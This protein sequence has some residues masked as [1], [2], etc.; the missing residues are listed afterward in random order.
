M[1]IL[2][3]ALQHDYLQHWRRVLECKWCGSQNQDKFPTEIAIH[4]PD[5]NRPLVFIFPQLFVCLN[6]GKAEI[7]EEFLVP[8]D[9]RRALA[10]REHHGTS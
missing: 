10:K 8:E 2:I 7:A 3:C 9:E 1:Q 6:C 5:T 4:L